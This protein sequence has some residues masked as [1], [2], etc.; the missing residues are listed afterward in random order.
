VRGS[1]LHLV[2]GLAPGAAVLG[3]VEPGGRVDARALEAQLWKFLR[4]KTRSTTSKNIFSLFGAELCLFCGIFKEKL[5]T[6]AVKSFGIKASFY[7]SSFSR[8]LP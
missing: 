6:C 7:V 1:E 8:P 4:G 5:R 3:E 2:E